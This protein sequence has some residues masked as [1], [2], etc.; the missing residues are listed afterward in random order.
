SGIVMDVFT[1]E[2]GV[3]FYTGNFMRGANTLKGGGK[4]DLRTAFCL[5]TQH[6]PDSPNQPSFPTTVLEPGA[7]YKTKTVYQF[8]TTP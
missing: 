3:Q 4:D 1:E 8:S 5:E 6:F 7:V 2:P